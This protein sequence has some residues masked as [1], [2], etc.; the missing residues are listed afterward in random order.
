MDPYELTGLE[1]HLRD[2]EGLG[3]ARRC[4]FH[5][6]VKTSSDDGMFDAP[7]YK[8]EAEMDEAAHMWEYDPANDQRL[9]CALPTG[10]RGT[11]SVR[12]GASCLDVVDDEIPF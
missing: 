11:E 3:D 9:Y 2:S 8:C 4:S 1:E 6:G 7:C 5:P 10:P 12:G